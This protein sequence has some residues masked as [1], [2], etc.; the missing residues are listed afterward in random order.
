MDYK[1]AMITSL[2]LQQTQIPEGFI[3]LGLGDPPPS[4][5]PLDVIQNAAQVILAQN[6]NSFLQYGVEQGYGPFR[7]ALSNFLSIGCGFPVQPE[8]LLT[9]NGIS[10]AL[11]LIC[12]LFT[13]TGDT[14]FVEEPT[15]FLALRIFSDH[16]LKIIPIQTDESGLIIE[17]L[18]EK[19][20]TI[21]PKFLYIIPTFQNPTGHT[22]TQSRRDRLVELSKEYDFMIVADEVYQFLSYTQ[23]PPKSF[24]SYTDIENIITLGSFS[25]ILAPGLRLGWL[26]AHPEKMKAFTGCGL[27][28][29]GG[30]L[31]PFTSAIVTEI[32][33]S[34]ELDKNIG[35][36]KSIYGERLKVMDEALRQYLPQLKYTIPHGG[37]FFWVQ[38]PDGMDA[39][40]LRARTPAFKV[41]FRPGIKFSSQNQLRDY[42]RMGFAFYEPAKIREGIMRFANCLKS[43]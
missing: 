21:R 7:V 26:H 34:G 8:N 22:L 10:G 19:L 5:L 41:D 9:T 30:G 43:K 17:A 6:N 25:K 36:L 40:E 23:Q 31:N 39:S 28:D 12:D 42:I 2:A 18:Q 35:R 29:S 33:E 20:G 15:Y 14:I 3:D 1:A 38:L 11:D 24:A 27:L 13:E 4:L 32:L 37:Y 16:K